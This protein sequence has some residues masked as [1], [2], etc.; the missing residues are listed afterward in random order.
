MSILPDTRRKTPSQARAAVTMAA[1]REAFLKLLR[2]EGSAALNTN[3][4]AEVAGVSIGSLYQYYQD[5]YAIAADICNEVLREEL[6]GID[7][8]SRQTV[9]IARHS[10][11]ETIAFI[12]KGHVVRERRLYELLQDFYLEL[13]WRYDFGATVVEQSTHHRPTAAWLP[14]LLKR[15]A[16]QVRVTDW[17]RASALVVDVIEGAIHRTLDRRP[18]ALFDDTFVVDLTELVLRYLKKSP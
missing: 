11:D 18:Q 7:A 1:I 17:P 14:R 15:H 5:K 12:V 10:L 9:A 16:G 2:E 13:H 3:R 4:I 6:E 8:M